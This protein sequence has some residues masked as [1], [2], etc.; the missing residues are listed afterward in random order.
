MLAHTFQIFD[1]ARCCATGVCGPAVDPQ[2]VQFAA[3][4]E[5][6][7]AQGIMV[8]R[9]NLAQSPGAFVQNALVKAVLELQGE[10]ALPVLLV[11][12]QVAATGTYPPRADLAAWFKLRGAAAPEPAPAGCGCGGAC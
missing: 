11:N 9:F 8:Q 12:G 2:L 7:K 4:L 5:W 1:P 10:T 3:D 6:L